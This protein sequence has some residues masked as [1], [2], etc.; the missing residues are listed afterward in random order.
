ME[1]RSTQDCTMMDLRN[2]E[3][4][5]GVKIPESLLRWMKAG[6]QD[7]DWPVLE[8]LPNELFTKIQTLK[9]EMKKLRSEDV[10][11]FQQLEAL[12]EGME[13]MRWLWEENIPQTSLSTNQSSQNP[14]FIATNQ[15]ISD[16]DQD[17]LQPPSLTTAEHDKGHGYETLEGQ[18]SSSQS[19]VKPETQRMVL[20][21]VESLGAH[22]IET[23]R[24]VTF[25]NKDQDQDPGLL[26]AGQLLGY[27]IH[28]R[29]VE[30]EDDVMF[31]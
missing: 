7:Y 15:T 4:K 6:V 14:T 12:N 29:W 18:R 16:L 21:Q 8:Y 13:C 5:V 25:Q 30:H 28:W 3:T 11:I 19:V 27:D 10:K 20:G 22:C 23:P 31:L 24:L 26:R 1:E 2:L 17:N 9:M